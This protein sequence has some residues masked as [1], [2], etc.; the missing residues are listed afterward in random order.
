MV[1]TAKPVLELPCEYGNVGIGDKTCRIGVSVD[2]AKLKLKTADDNLC[3]HRLTLKMIGV[4][5][6]DDP[7]QKRMFDDLQDMDGI[8]DIKGFGVSQGSISFGL[9]FSKADVDLKQ[10]GGFAKRSGRLEIFGVE[11]IPDDEDEEEE[12][13]G[14][15]P[16][17]KRGRRASSGGH[18]GNGEDRSDK[19]L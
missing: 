8:A 14:I 6:G 15:E 9:T 4:P 19:D 2:R 18:E 3:C 13:E 11:E 16:T 12:E 5:P 10:L 7:E 1:K 17:R